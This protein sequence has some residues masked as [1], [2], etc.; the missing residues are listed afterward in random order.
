MA[1]RAPSKSFNSDL[2]LA[3]SG[4]EDCTRTFP[5]ARLRGARNSIE[6]SPC[7]SM[8][9]VTAFH[10]GIEKSCD[11][12]LSSFRS[13]MRT[14]SP[15]RTRKVGFDSALPSTRTSYPAR[16]AGS[17]EHCRHLTAAPAAESQRSWQPRATSPPRFLLPDAICSVT[18]V[19]PTSMPVGYMTAKPAARPSAIGTDVRC[20]MTGRGPAICFATW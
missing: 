2:Y 5:A 19:Q 15:R 13:T 7:P 10:A 8:R 12:P 3:L 4:R 6:A 16:R 14:R 11:I 17:P 18:L 20:A 9:R 1:N